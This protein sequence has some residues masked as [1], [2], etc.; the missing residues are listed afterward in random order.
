MSSDAP[1]GE[2]KVQYTAQAVSPIVSG[3]VKLSVE[4]NSFVATGLFN[5][6][7]V[8]FVDIDSIEF[9][10]YVVTVKTT[11]G[12]YVFS[13]MG[14]W[15]QPFYDKLCESYKKAVLRA[16][17]VYGNKLL[18]ADG[19][20]NFTE[21]GANVKGSKAPIAVYG[22][23]VTVLPPNGNVRRIPL[24]FMNAIDRKDYEL[25]MKLN[26]GESYT[27]SRLGYDTRSFAEMLE[28]Q[29]RI[30]REKSIANI[31]DIDY[32]LTVAQASQLAMLMP[33]G[34]AASMGNI[35]AAAPSFFNAIEAKIAESR[36]AETYKAFKG[37]C[38]PADI[39]VGFKKNEPK[40]G[41]SD[42]PKGAPDMA[43]GIP[44]EFAHL[45][46]K[47][48]QGAVPGGEAKEGEEGK[49]EQPPDPYLFWMIAPS[50]NGQFAAVEF[51]V[52]PGESAATFVYRTNGDFAKAAMHLNRALESI[53]FKREVIRLTD[54]ELKKPENV[55]YNMAAK[56]TTSL[57]YIRANFVGRVIHTKTWEQ[58]LKEMWGAKN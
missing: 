1:E 28:K 30:L 9:L 37:M 3:E 35:A 45:I 12:D 47:E 11:D 23:C 18:T 25:T 52:E 34:A 44:K 22:N 20:Y 4:K 38:N 16:F 13:R 58:K 43:G 50:P 27:L 32:S 14:S 33:E 48:L 2:S 36:A 53:D 42:S 5:V 26:L 54:E 17:F 6:A 41:S 55:D 57:K 7:E 8:P 51:A 10:N 21:D 15:A 24:C 39:W 56:R 31:K 19:D 46:P 40:R 29:I 49:E